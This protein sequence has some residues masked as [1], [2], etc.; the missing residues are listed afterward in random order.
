MLHK[1]LHC[2]RNGHRRGPVATELS[3]GEIIRLVHSDGP[4]SASTTSEQVRFAQPVDA[5]CS[6]TDPG[7]L[8]LSEAGAR[9]EAPFDPS[10]PPDVPVSLETLNAQADV[11]A[12]TVAQPVT[13]T[14][15]RHGNHRRRLQRRLVNLNEITQEAVTAAGPRLGD[16]KVELALDASVPC[17]VGDYRQLP[18]ALAG[19]I[20]YMARLITKVE[21]PITV[22]TSLRDSALRGESLVRLRIRAR[23]TA[24]P[25]DVRATLFQ[26]LSGPWA[27]AKVTELHL[28]GASRIISEH[29]GFLSS[30]LSPEGDPCFSLEFPAI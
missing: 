13:T 23:R 22:E 4:T 19:L 16:I 3:A 10:R 20:R 18:E 8:P 14:R 11:T 6:T 2:K 21:G 30:E 1:I 25:D 5:E 15:R 12:R 24:V 26:A 17:I 9:A 28:Y 27:S 29:G 7:R